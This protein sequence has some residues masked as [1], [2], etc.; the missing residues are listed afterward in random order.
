[1]DEEAKSISDASA[2][3]QDINVTAQSAEVVQ[4]AAELPDKVSQTM[5]I[6]GSPSDKP[7]ANADK[8]KGLKEVLKLDSKDKDQKM[9][10]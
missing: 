9:L 5:A 2:T 1:M 3:A 6:E 4:P 10:S 7:S 8:T